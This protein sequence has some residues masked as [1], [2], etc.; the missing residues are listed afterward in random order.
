VFSLSSTPRRLVEAEESAPCPGP[1][2]LVDASPPPIEEPISRSK[3][4]FIKTLT[5]KT[6]T[7]DVEDDDTVRTL[8]GKI[9]DKVRP[10]P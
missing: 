8:K 4:I 7:I 6:I 2:A 9:M 10:S 3:Q 5:G 1:P